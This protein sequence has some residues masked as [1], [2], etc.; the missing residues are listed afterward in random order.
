MML[1]CVVNVLSLFVLRSVHLRLAPCMLI[2]KPLTVVAE[3]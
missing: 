3:D 2:R 1:L